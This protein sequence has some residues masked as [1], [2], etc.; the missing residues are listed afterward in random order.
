MGVQA[1][2]RRHR[3]LAAHENAPRSG[4]H[5]ARRRQGPGGQARTGR[6][7]GSRQRDRAISAVVRLPSPPPAP[8]PAR[9]A[10]P[11]WTST[12]QRQPRPAQGWLLLAVLAGVAVLVGLL[13]GSIARR[14]T[15]KAHGPSAA[16]GFA[17]G[18]PNVSQSYLRGV[19]LA[20]IS[21]R[22]LKRANS[23]TCEPNPS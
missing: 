4:E 9:A 22:W 1:A 23:F 20:A 10:A 3:V 6:E 16:P 21:Q 17:D 14:A 7:P 11:G 13:G 2:D 5:R 8:P 15:V 18:F 19:T 12:P